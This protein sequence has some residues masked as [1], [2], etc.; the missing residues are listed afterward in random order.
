MLIYKIRKP[1][2]LIAAGFNLLHL[3]YNTACLPLM[4]SPPALVAL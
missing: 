1:A 4:D 3:F 2:A